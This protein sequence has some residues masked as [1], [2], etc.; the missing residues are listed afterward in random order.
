VYNRPHVVAGLLFYLKFAKKN[1]NHKSNKNKPIDNN[2]PKGRGISL[3]AA[4]LSREPLREPPPILA[5]VLA[6]VVALGPLHGPPLG[7]VELLPHPAI[8]AGMARAAAD[9]GVSVEAAVG[10]DEGRIF[11]VDRDLALLGG[12]VAA[13]PQGS[14]QGH[15]LGARVGEVGEALE[16]PDEDVVDLEEDVGGVPDDGVGVVVGRGV[17]PEVEL[18]LL[19]AVAIGPN[20]G[21]EYH[22][23][24]TGV[25][26]ELHVDLVAPL[27]G[28]GRK[29][30]LSTKQ[31]HRELSTDPARGFVSLS[32][33]E[34]ADRLT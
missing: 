12:P 23:L 26:H 15:G 33:R 6:H 28:A 20:V 25:A 3:A 22:G 8:P 18:V 19:L 14:M 16:G 31:Q 32:S 17:E 2:G 4:A 21:V 9:A 27:V 1:K 24:A 11:P 7:A 34:K 29:L 5:V 30:Q 13:V 10:D